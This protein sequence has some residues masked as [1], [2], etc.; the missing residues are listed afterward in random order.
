MK[1]FIWEIASFPLGLSQFAITSFYFKLF[2]KLESSWT[3]PFL[4]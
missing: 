2:R 1:I 4:L 3:V